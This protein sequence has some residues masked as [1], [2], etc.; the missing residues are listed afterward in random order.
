MDPARLG[1]LLADLR[2]GWLDPTWIGAR[3]CDAGVE[4]LGV[5]G[6]GIMLVGGEGHESSFGVSDDVVRRLEVLQFTLGEGPGVAAHAA[7]RLVSEPDLEVATRTRWPAFGPAA[8]GVGIRAVFSLPLC[9]GGIGLGALSLYRRGPG[10]LDP[11]QLADGFVLAEIV[12]DV[13][14]ALQAGVA[15]G[16]D[17]IDIDVP[18]GSRA[19]VHQASGMIS[20]QLDIPIGDALVRLRGYAY[21]E[22]RSINDVARAVIERR[23]RIDEPP[24]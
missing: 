10:W 12:T 23:L 16:G 7:G 6:V 3:L 11:E 15:I 19:D 24:G 20:Q 5:D 4:L 21:A 22:Q 17:P 1:V 2:A 9:V 14:L 18:G 8:A 13:L